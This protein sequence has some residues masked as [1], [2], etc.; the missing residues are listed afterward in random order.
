MN[1][2]GKF[3]FSLAIAFQA[4]PCNATQENARAGARIAEPVQITGLLNLRFENICSNLRETGQTI[5]FPNDVNKCRGSL[6]SLSKNQ[7]AAVFD[8]KGPA[9]LVY[10]IE[11][12]RSARTINESG[13]AIIISEFGLSR[14]PET[15]TTGGD[16]VFISTGSAKA[17]ELSYGQYFGTFTITVNYE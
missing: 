10:T 3:L 12:P 13:N 8:V 4:I 11:L 9:N 14:K 15:F 7:T 6:S 2:I 1:L 5:I 17:N 16:Q